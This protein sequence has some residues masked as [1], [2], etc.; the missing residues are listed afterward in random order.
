MIALVAVPV[1]LI[2]DAQVVRA[3]GHT[4]VSGMLTHLALGQM[5]QTLCDRHEVVL[6]GVQCPGR[7]AGR[8]PLTKHHVKCLALF[9]TPG[10]VHVV[11]LKDREDNYLN[12]DDT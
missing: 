2:I 12:D 4:V 11:V 9:Q 5:T 1:E 8:D 7:C 6:I 3:I 10:Y